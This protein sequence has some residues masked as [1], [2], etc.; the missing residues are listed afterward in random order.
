MAAERKN[1]TSILKYL[2]TIL[3]HFHFATNLLKD[4]LPWPSFSRNCTEGRSWEP[5]LSE[6]NAV[7]PLE[8][9]AGHGQDL[10]RELEVG[11]QPPEKS[12]G[13]PLC[14]TTSTFSNDRE[15]RP[16]QK[17]SVGAVGRRSAQ[18]EDLLLDDQEYGPQK[19]KCGH[20]MKGLSKEA[21][22]R[23]SVIFI[24]QVLASRCNGNPG[25]WTSLRRST[26][27]TPL[28][29]SSP[30][31]SRRRQSHNRFWRPAM[32]SVMEL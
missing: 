12:P 32:V 6:E 2:D 9:D 4:F 14:S 15:R 19:A 10:K 13:D 3:L 31:L 16:K 17:T 11:E 7:E 1:R 8:G 5:G 20:V 23:N 30:A 29:G 25:S 22:S 18:A 21:A 26:V 24:T 28:T 27:G